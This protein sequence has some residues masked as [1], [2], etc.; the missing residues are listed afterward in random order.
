MILVTAFLQVEKF[1]AEKDLSGKVKSKKEND[2]NDGLSIG[3]LN[4]KTSSAKDG[5]KVYYE[6]YPI[7]MAMCTCLGVAKSNFQTILMIAWRTSRTPIEGRELEE[8][9]AEEWRELKIISLLILIS[10]EMESKFSM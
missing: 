4:K 9:Y 5:L 2:K 7:Y 1:L 6:L 8:W 10:I 3:I